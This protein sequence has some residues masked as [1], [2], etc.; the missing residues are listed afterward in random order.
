MVASFDPFMLQLIFI[1]ALVTLV[2][3]LAGHFILVRFEPIPYRV[4]A[5]LEAVPV[6]VMTTLVVPAAL[7]GTWI[8]W[9]ALATAAILSTRLPFVA[10]VIGALAVLLA[11]RQAF[12]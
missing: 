4:E 9:V 10:A 12:G 5:A 11:L 3:R 2:N 7:N 8:E 1:G 6:A